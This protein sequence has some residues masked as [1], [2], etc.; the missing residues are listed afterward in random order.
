MEEVGPS[1][2]TFSKAAAAVSLSSATLVQRFGTRD[3]M[4]QATLLHSWNRLD[5]LTSMADAEAPPTPSG[6]ISLLL[7]VMPGSAADYNVTEGLLLLREDLRDP[8]LR[9]RGRAWGDYL[10]EALGRRLAPQAPSAEQLGWQMLAM[11]QGVIIWWAFKRD[12][13][14]DKAIRTALEEWCESVGIGV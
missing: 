1:G 14:P 3:A 4:M 5:A 13:D 2:L 12:G 11:W 6:A 10:A 8:V 7:R 9:A